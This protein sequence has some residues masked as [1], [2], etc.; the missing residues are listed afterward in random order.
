MA[1]LGMVTRQANPGDVQPAHGYKPRLSLSE[2]MRQLHFADNQE[3]Y[4]KARK[5]RLMEELVSR[6]TEVQ[7][8]LKESQEILQSIDMILNG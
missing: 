1:K 3:S 5:S 7:E 6:R 4:Y 8:R 2:L